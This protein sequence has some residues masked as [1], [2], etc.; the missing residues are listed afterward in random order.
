MTKRSSSDTNR[1]D[2]TLRKVNSRAQTANQQ[3]ESEK[4]MPKEEI[5]VKEH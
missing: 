2:G 1:E 5:P 3:S 4:K